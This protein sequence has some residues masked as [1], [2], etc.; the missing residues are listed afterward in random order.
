[1]LLQVKPDKNIKYQIKLYESEN[2]VNNRKRAYKG[3]I[4]ILKV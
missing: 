3:A 4:E 2:L 1:M